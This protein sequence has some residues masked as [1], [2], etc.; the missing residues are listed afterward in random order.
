MIFRRFTLLSFALL[1]CAASSVAFAA[2]AIMLKKLLIAD[3][4]AKI[5]TL[6]IG[7]GGN[8]HVVVQDVAALSASDF[9]AVIAPFVGRPFS[10]ELVNEIAGV[11]IDYAKAHDR[12][13]SIAAPEQAESVQAGELRFVVVSPAT[14][15]VPLLKKL[16]IADKEPKVTA[17]PIASGGDS[18]VVVQD[19]AV[20]SAA[21]FPAVVAPFMGKPFS[22]ELVNEVAGAIKQYG[23][24]HDRILNILMPFAPEARSPQDIA[25]GVLRFAVVLS[26]YNQL[27]IKGN[28]WF[29]NKLL[30]QKL[31]IKPG[32]EISLSRLD[33]AVNWANTNPFRRIQVLLNTADQQPGQATLVVGVRERIPLRFTASF[34]DTGNEIIGEHHLTESLQFANLWGLDHEIS[35]QFLTTEHSH[36]L[37]AHSLSYRVPLPWRHYLQLST[38]YSKVAT[39]FFGGAFEQ[40]G[41][42]LGANLRYT[43]PLRGGNN[44]AEVFAAFDFKDSNNDLEY[45][46]GIFKRNTKSDIFQFSTGFSVVWRDAHG[47]WVLGGNASFSPGRINSRNRDDA[48]QNARFGST[49]RY[50]YA[51]LSLQRL[52]ALDRGW[53]FHSR[54]YVQISTQNLLSSEQLSIGG[55]STVRGFD[56]R[57]FAGDQ[58][59]VFSNDL[60]A[61]LWKQTL[62]FLPK[63]RPPLETRFLFFYDAASVDYKHRFPSDVAF[64]PLASTGVGLRSNFGPNLNVSFD[65]GWQIT[66]LPTPA[67]ERSRGHVKVVLAF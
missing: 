20:L 64:R 29:S 57:V 15:E 31:G 33:D 28:R 38:S 47:A 41:E 62:H 14:A 34:D 48:F 27:E 61:P 6:P 13:V 32:D 65:Y 49:A 66:R 46:G 10:I 4:E 19:V 1:T 7:S 60:K 53:E 3:S 22:L 59:F 26:R 43:A 44:P 25:A 51:L 24:K 17:L 40:K 39:S 45:G 54:S 56:E 21:D 23:I 37:Q 11:I 50:A 12:I 2:D 5:K 35:Y 36:G 30:A 8:T 9:P 16:L 55:S 63:N 67:T 18:P 52:Q 58:G 42:N